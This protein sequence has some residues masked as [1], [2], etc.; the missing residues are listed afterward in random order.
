M[1][2]AHRAGARRRLNDAPDIFASMAMV[3]PEVSVD[4]AEA[5]ARIH[6]GIDARAQPIRGER[7]RNFHL[8]SNDGRE[9]L[10]KIANPAEDATFRHMQIEALRHIAHTALD[11]QV[12]RCVPLPDGSVELQLPHA[13]SGALDARL[14]TWV[15]GLSFHEARRSAAQRAAYGAALAQLQMALV[16][17]THPA[18]EHPVPWDLKHTVRLRE[19][20]FSIK[21]AEARAAVHALVDE[22]EEV[23]PPIMPALRR[24]MVHNDAT[25]MNVL[26]NPE[27]QD[28]IAGIIDF[29]DIAETPVVFDVAI[30][31]L[32]QP[33]PDMSTAEAVAH[34]VRGFH[35]V[36]PLTREEANLLPLLVACRIAMGI[37]LVCWHRHTQPDNPH[38]ARP[39]QTFGEALSLIDE[40]RAPA[41]A[42]AVY[43]ACGFT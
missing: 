4:T 39:N 27:N 19:I 13:G 14:H 41:V 30:A 8:R 32:S 37:A 35:A 23:V 1:A 3:P 38:Y 18:R 42:S 25:R 33:A 9:F 6:W 11:F 16:D 7:D 43:D 15:P 10:L 2:D 22:F 34:F 5:V 36:R 26:V 31:A 29:G 17:F 21:H 28:R 40:F 24:Q 12:P 20:A